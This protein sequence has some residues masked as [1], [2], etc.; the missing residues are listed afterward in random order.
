LIGAIGIKRLALAA[1]ALAAAAFAAL[2]LLSILIPADTVRDAVKAEIRAVTGLDPVLRGGVAVSL[3]PRGEVNFEEVVLGDSSTGAPAITVEELTARLRFFPLLIGRVE[4]ADVSLV[5]PTIAI[6]FN[7]DGGSNWSSHVEMLAR[8]LQP[9]RERVASFSEI[10]ISDGTVVLRDARRD[11]SE[12]LSGVEF[13]LA[14][15]SISKTFAASGSFR[16]HGETIDGNFSLSDFVAALLGDKSGLKVRLSGAPAKFAFDGYISYRPTLR[17]EGTLAADTPSL[18]DTLRWATRH[19]P[20]GGGFGRFALKAQTNVANGNVALSAVNVELDGN[21]GE[22]AL[23]FDSNGRQALQGTLATE[24][25][26]LTPYVSAIRFLTSGSDRNWE[27]APISLDGLN[28]VDVDLRL[29]AARVTIANARLGRTAVAANLRGGHL[30]VTIGES[31]AFGGL[32]KGSFALAQASAGADLKAQLQ[33]A[34]V[35]LDQ[36]LGD[37][38]GFRRMEGKGTLGFAVESKGDSVYG[39]AKA[40]NGSVNLTSRKGAIVGVNIEQLLKRL[41]RSPLSIGNELRSGKTPFTQ[42]LVNL[43]IEQGTVA[44]DDLRLEGPAL[45]LALAGSA[46]IPARDLDLNGTATLVSAPA[47]GAAEAAPVFELPF[48]LAGPWDDPE[49]RP[50]VRVLMRHSGAAAPL[51]DAIERVK[52]RS[53]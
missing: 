13:A 11:L 1:A 53:R 18:R 47:A 46:S 52:N 33:F 7:P 8:A 36:C 12:T 41:E 44:V 25:L 24:A 50:D 34:D 31:E 38:F 42:L 21:V 5:R 10:R 2:V 22:G 17:M 45:R 30:T 49:F 16:W 6:S 19:A 40:L 39:L 37:L 14:W 23:T 27:Q 48:V 4:I 29:S 35:D 15:P 20:P 32:V 51:M 28:D 9:Q 26:D 43:K 3:F